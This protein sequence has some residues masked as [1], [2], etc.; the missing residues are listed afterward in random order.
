[1]PPRFATCRVADKPGHNR[2]A[3]SAVPQGG[4]ALLFILRVI[5]TV[6]DRINAVVGHVMAWLCLVLVLNTFLVVVLRYAFNLGEP[7]MTETYIYTHA[8]IFLLGAGY[9]LLHDGHVRIDLIYAGASPRYKATINL[10]GTI[11]F[12]LPVMWLFYTKGIDF[13]W[14]SFSRLET[15]P[16]AGGIPALYVVKAAIPVMAVL[17]GAQFFSLALRSIE[18]LITGDPHALPHADEEPMA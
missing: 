13:F 8:Y 12:A 2:P 3:T 1:M 16:E 11:V 18:T 7:W 4:G 17:L 9:T 14:R 6:I 5:A 15:S 10:I